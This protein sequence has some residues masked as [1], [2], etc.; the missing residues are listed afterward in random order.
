MAGVYHQHILPGLLATMLVVKWRL[1]LVP[2]HF[3]QQEV[4][5]LKATKQSFHTKDL[6]HTIDMM[7]LKNIF[8]D[9]LMKLCASD[10]NKP[11]L[12]D[13]IDKIDKMPTDEFWGLYRIDFA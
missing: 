1:K 11:E 6:S 5:W 7:E 8:V 12:D 3:D 9:D 13:L 4:I 2:T 10:S